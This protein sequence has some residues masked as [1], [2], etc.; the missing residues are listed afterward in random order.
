MDIEIHPTP[1]AL[2]DRPHPGPA[3]VEAEAVGTP[4]IAT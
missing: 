3:P 4:N 2:D 1:E